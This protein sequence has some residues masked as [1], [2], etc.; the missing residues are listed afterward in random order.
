MTTG[1]LDAITGTSSSDTRTMEPDGTFSS[2]AVAVNRYSGERVSVSGLTRS[3]DTY[4]LGGGGNDTLNGTD[5]NDA[6]F[7]STAGSTRTDAN[8]TN[9][10][11]AAH[12]A[13]IE[14]FYLG[15]GDDLLDLT[16]GAAGAGSYASSVALRGEAS[17]TSASGTAGADVIWSGA[18]PDNLA[19]D[20][21]SMSGT[22]VGGGDRMHG[23]AGGDFIY[24]DVSGTLSGT[25]TGGDDVLHGGAGTD[26]LRGDAGTVS[27]TATCGD[28]HLNGGAGNDT[29]G[30]DA[31]NFTSFTGARGA[32]TFDFDA[33]SGQD[34]IGDFQHGVDTIR[35]DPS[36]GFDDFADLTITGTTNAV[37]ALNGT[38]DQVTLTGVS[39]A[40][41]DAGDFEFV[42]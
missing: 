22:A 24:G 6:L 39:A 31:S 13:S 42:A 33:G 26:T 34:T 2:T 18:G 20:Y 17:G 9:V 25:A 37:I 4:S 29:L 5:G 32:D 1:I 30:G 8:G 12:F 21:S 27:D 10:A 14:N 40:T 15:L 35:I 23:S 11:S 19:G 3:F 16:A 28:D 7:H 36:Y 38:T 41:L